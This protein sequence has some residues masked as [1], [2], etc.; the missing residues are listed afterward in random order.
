MYLSFSQ[1]WRRLPMLFANTNQI[2]QVVA[3]I[4]RGIALSSKE[5]SFRKG[6]LPQ[7]FSY[8]KLGT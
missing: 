8:E 2:W 1:R 3:G 5:V 6:F 4:F 7:R